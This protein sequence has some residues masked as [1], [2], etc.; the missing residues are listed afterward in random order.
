[1]K[2]DRIIAV[3]LSLFMFLLIATPFS[4]SIEEKSNAETKQEVVTVIKEQEVVSE[5]TEVTTVEEEQVIV[6]AETNEVEQEPVQEVV[7]ETVEESPQASIYNCYTSEELN[8]LFCV[9]QAE[10]GDYSFEQKCNVA[11][12]IFNRIN[13]PEFGSTMREVLCASQF[14]T[15]ASGKYLTVTPSDSTISACEYVFEFGSTAGQALYF[16]NMNSNSHSSYAT[17]L[18]SDGAHKFYY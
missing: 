2:E 9:V 4:L 5:E 18:F 12:V 13:R 6:E 14:S 7:E 1:M 11:S 16:E 3:T 15:I 17:Y 10:I 8:L